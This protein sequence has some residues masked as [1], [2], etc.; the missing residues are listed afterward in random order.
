MLSG[1]QESTVVFLTVEW[2]SLIDRI[3]LKMLPYLASSTPLITPLSRKALVGTVDE[4][5][6][7]EHDLEVALQA[8]KAGKSAQAISLLESAQ[9]SVLRLGEHQRNC[10]APAYFNQC[11][12]PGK[13]TSAAHEA[14]AITEM[15]EQILLDLST[16]D[17][18]QAQQVNK[19]MRDVIDDSTALQQKMFLLPNI[20]AQFDVLSVGC[21]VRSFRPMKRE[22]GISIRCAQAFPITRIPECQTNRRLHSVQARFV[23]PLPRPGDRVRR[24]LITQPPLKEVSM[25]IICCAP[26]SRASIGMLR[27]EHSRLSNRDG[28]TIGELYDEVQRVL[29]EHHNCPFAG[30]E[31][32]TVNGSVN[33]QV[34][35]EA[36]IEL[37]IDHP[38]VVQDNLEQ[39]A[40]RQRRKRHLAQER[41]M[42]DFCKAKELAHTQGDPIPT[43]EQFNLAAS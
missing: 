6:K 7:L 1:K 33:A 39:E 15:L 17:L 27:P 20:G 31:M 13:S 21:V 12:K 4:Q 11:S 14:F 18:L 36:K 32:H 43:F 38:E 29:E 5:F 30:P 35:F 2:L 3:V 22:P 19:R 26:N 23:Q 40:K 28:L 37:P 16:A 41:T 8:F 9:Q 24:M 34:Y 10:L 25:A 42:R